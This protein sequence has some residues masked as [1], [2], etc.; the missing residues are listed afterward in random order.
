[1][2]AGA[3]P[4]HLECHEDTDF[5]TALDRMVAENI[6]EQNRNQV[7]TQTVDISVPYHVRSTTKKTYGMFC[8]LDFK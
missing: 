8:S 2:P 6:R 3:G 5:M 4:K 1:M 7:K